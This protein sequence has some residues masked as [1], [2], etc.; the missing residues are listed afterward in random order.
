FG[1]L[2]LQGC[3]RLPHRLIAETAA[4]GELRLLAFRR[5]ESAL[6]DRR[7]GV[8][9]D[10]LMRT[11]PQDP[12]DRVSLRTFKFQRADAVSKKDHARR[13]AITPGSAPL[14]VGVVVPR[15]DRRGSQQRREL[16]EF[17]FAG[18]EAAVG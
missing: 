3:R 4:R 15:L 6:P 12:A 17:A 16:R 7:A 1:E 5:P 14:D 10:G 8:V 2:F 18:T 9:L 11:F 13:Y